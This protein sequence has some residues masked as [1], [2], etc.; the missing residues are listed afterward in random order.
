M[1]KR[2]KEDYEQGKITLGKEVRERYESATYGIAGNHSGVQICGWTRK[3]LRGQGVCYKQKFYGVDCHRCCQMSPALAWCE[4]NCIYCWRPME[5]M[6]KT[7][8]ESAEVDSPK[9][10]IERTVPARRKIMSGIG[11][12]KDVQKDL[13]RESFTEFPSHWAIS[14]SGEPTIYPRLGE[15]VEELRSRDEVKSIF[16]VTNGQEPEMIEKM[17]KDKNLPTQLYV[18]LSAPNQKLFNKINRPVYADGWQRLMRTL[19]MLRR[20]GC[21]KVIRLTILKGMNDKPEHLAEYAKIMDDSY[22]DFIEIKSYMFL[23]LS[24]QRLKKE[25]MA[26][27]KSIKEWSLRLLDRMPGYRLEAEDETSR[28]VLLKRKK[29]PVDNIIKK[30]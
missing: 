22:T 5:W 7:S 2:I 23:G 26:S 4:Q 9:E 6:K 20:L 24:R 11:G 25:N 19:S 17:A 1:E 8:M 14:L 29:S 3:A 10:I 12:A 15:L 28:I 13:F 27:H 30:A 18:S 21:R 16:I